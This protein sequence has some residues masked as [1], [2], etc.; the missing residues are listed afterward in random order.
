[1]REDPVHKGLLFAGTERAVYVS[2]DDGNNWLPLRRNMPA[3]SIRD[4]VVHNSDVVVATHGRSFW[5]L[6]NITSLRQLNENVL[7]PEPFLFEPDEA[8]RVR[9][10][11]NTDTPL[12]PEEPAGENPP[13][14]AMVDY[15]LPRDAKEV[16]L[17]IT[18]QSHRTVRKYSSTDISE[19]V[20]EKELR[21][22]EYWIRP[23]MRIPANAGM[24]RFVWDLH[25]APPESLPRSYGIAAVLHNTASQPFGPWVMPGTYSLSLTADGRT[26]TQPITI[27]MD[28]RINA[29]PEILRQQ[30]DLSMICYRGLNEIHG[31]IGQIHK[32]RNQISTLSG[33][34]IDKA[35][36]DSLNSFSTRLS[37]IEGG[38][39]PE[40]VDIMYFTVDE[41]KT[42]KETFN[43][44][45]TKLLY[46]LTLLQGADAKPTTAQVN[47]AGEEDKV[48]NAMLGWWKTFQE[49]DLQAFNK[50]LQLHNLEP[51]K[52][53]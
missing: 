13:D 21:V 32:L 18:D 50:S 20:N 31:V 3:S 16:T 51:L 15:H 23:S 9:W 29:S 49:G 30:F 44:L 41:G 52:V 43:G 24:H 42:V 33:K 35:V 1:M 6:D 8:Y 19:T 12:P 34:D 45:Q 39:P 10:N 28:P 11:L 27:K 46:V 37:S 53:E 47:A 7:R 36:K 48:L 14:G 2:L 25:Y 26:L 40:E 38:G 5:I 4:L 17:E 22:P